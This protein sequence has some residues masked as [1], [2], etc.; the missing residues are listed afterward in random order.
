M[1]RE[2]PALDGKN[3]IKGSHDQCR[4]VQG[5]TYGTWADTEAVVEERWRASGGADR[6]T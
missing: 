5:K 1:T 2:L 4:R 3:C 6:I